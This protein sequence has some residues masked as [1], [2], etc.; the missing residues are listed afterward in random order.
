MSDPKILKGY[1][2]A[3]MTD[4]GR[5]VFWDGTLEFDPYHHYIFQEE[6][7]GNTYFLIP[8]IP[9]PPPKDKNHVFFAL[10]NNKHFPLPVFALN[11]HVTPFFWPFHVTT[12]IMVPTY[13]V[14]AS[15]MREELMK[16]LPASSVSDYDRLMQEILPL[17]TQR[18][19]A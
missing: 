5:V 2:L 14:W 12:D 19:R 3:K 8:V 13:D 18:V 10:A 7:V 4:E 6:G 17:F 16:T 11:H 9:S 1:I 15:T